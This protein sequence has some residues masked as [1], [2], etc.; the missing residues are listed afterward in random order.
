M[1]QGEK[2]AK[3]FL[4]HRTVVE[5]ILQKVP[6]DKF[7][8]KPWPGA[9]S[10]GELAVHMADSAQR[11]AGWVKSGSAE[12][13]ESLTDWTPDAVRTYVH[14]RTEQTVEAMKSTSDEAME[15]LVQTKQLFGVDLPGKVLLNSMRDHEIHHKGQLFV[16][17]R[18]AGVEEMPFFINRNV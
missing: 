2:F 10:L 1:S 13:F 18:M 11:F 16:Y 8:L 3:L 7:D 14:E 9:L 15:A 6:D 5:D 17:A 12:K 4:S